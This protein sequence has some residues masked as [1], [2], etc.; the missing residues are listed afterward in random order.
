MSRM[1]AAAAAIAAL[2]V[3]ATASANDTDAPRTLKATPATCAFEGFAP[4]SCPAR[5]AK[6]FEFW[7]RVVE[8]N[9]ANRGLEVD[10]A[11]FGHAG[12]LR[13][14]L[15]KRLGDTVDL[16]LSDTTKYRKVGFDGASARIS[17]LGLIETLDEFPRATIY[18]ESRLLGASN[19]N[20]DEP[21]LRAVRIIVDL[22]DLPRPA[23]GQ[24]LKVEYFGNRDL[25][26]AP[27]A[28]GV[29]QQVDFDWAGS[30]P[31]ALASAGKTDNFGIRWS[32]SVTVPVAGTYTFRT[33]SDDGVRLTVNGVTA[34]D[35]WTQHSAFNN[36]IPVSLAAGANTIELKYF[37]QTGVSVARLHWLAPGA[38]GFV[39]IPATAL[40]TS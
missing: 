36:D 16:R 37:E 25:T 11:G 2:A 6:L 14:H 29:D 31:A 18:V 27:I 32:G 21:I 28:T 40:R 19:W 30:A 34:I 7:G 17:E 15:S 20:D 33:T 10:L 24:G 4:T 12:K 38:S 8:T 5:R 35:N 3:P 9:E 39:A 1:L 26:G 22:S 23:A 13:S